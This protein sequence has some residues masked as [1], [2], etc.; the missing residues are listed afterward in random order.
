MLFAGVILTILV[1][2]A[3]GLVYFVH[4]RRTERD[5]MD[6]WQTAE[7]AQQVAEQASRA[8]TEFLTTM[9]H[10]IRTP[11]HSVIGSAEILLEDDGLNLEQR[12][13]LE[14]IQVSGT[15]LLNLVNDVLD[16]AKIE[17]GEVEISPEAFPLETLIDHSVSIVRTTAQ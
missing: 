3:A 16:L 13:Y 11:L 7:A 2:G 14:R 15:A 12:E 10:E 8:K 9:S 4:R 17:A 5:L 6:A 1:A